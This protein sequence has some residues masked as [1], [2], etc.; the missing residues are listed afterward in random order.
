MVRSPEIRAI[1][2]CGAWC[3]LRLSSPALVV[4]RPF[5]SLLEQ[6]CAMGRCFCDE[7]SGK[8]ATGNHQ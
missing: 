7:P 1:G 5:P 3:L 4:S 2:V 8:A 6:T